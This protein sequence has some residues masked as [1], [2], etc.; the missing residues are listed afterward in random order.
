[1]ALSHDQI[2]GTW[3]TVLLPIN[4]DESIDYD[5]LAQ[6]V[7]A[8]IGAGVNGLYTNGTAGELHTQSDEEFL[9]IN[10]M[11]AGLCRQAG[12][13]L[14]I[15]AS[16]PFAQGTLQ[17]IRATLFLEPDA[18]Q[19]ILPDW[20][21]L[22]E[23]EAV[24]FLQ[25][26]ALEAEGTSLVLYNP[27]HAKRV[28]DPAALGRIR[29]EVPQLVG[30]KLMDGSASWYGAMRHHLPNFSVGVP[31]HH[32]AT[33]VLNGAHCSYSNVAC[34]SP[35]GAVRWYAQMQNDP[36]G[37]L[38]T[39]GRINAFF[40]HH[41]VPLA[42]QGYV[43]PALDKFL[44]TVGGWAEVGTRLRWPYRWIPQEQAEAL[45]SEARRMLPGFWAD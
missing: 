24:A 41:V 36:L 43:N 37:A 12:V 8:M 30:V 20:V 7:N 5:R 31:G 33:G 19:V 17:R 22:S 45:R 42:A 25:R 39:E 35:H 34:L 15:G 14:Q 10:R 40:Q 27:P 29:G 2:V 16:H 13:P 11:V 44:A 4:P 3:G 21:V 38:E 6:S 28:F 9:E 23:K 18:Y 32:L 1:M 26:V